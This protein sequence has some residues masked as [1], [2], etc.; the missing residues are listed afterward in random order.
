MKYNELVDPLYENITSLNLYEMSDF[1]PEVTGL[2]INIILWARADSTEYGHSRYR[3][4]VNKNKKFSA[5]YLISQKPD[6]VL[7]TK[8]VKDRLSNS[9]EEEIQDFIKKY[10]SLFISL[11]DAKITSNEVNNEIL[12]I[13]GTY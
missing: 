10:A 4:K 6:R 1:T 7:R 5:I 12:K 11:I 8:R 2:P 3:I 9:E 13:R